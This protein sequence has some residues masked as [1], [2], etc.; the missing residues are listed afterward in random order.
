MIA[1][2]ASFFAVASWHPR[3]TS[4]I[5]IARR[6]ASHPSEPFA[7]NVN[8]TAVDPLRTFA[9]GV[10]QDVEDMRF[11]RHRLATPQFAARDVEHIIVER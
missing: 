3:V 10:Y 5:T 6:T 7:F 4:G 11:D 1:S 8:S 2:A 9:A